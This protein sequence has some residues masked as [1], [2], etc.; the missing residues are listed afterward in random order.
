[1]HS[2]RCFNH[3][4]QGR[5][6]CDGATN[7]WMQRSKRQETIKWAPH[8]AQQVLQILWGGSTTVKDIIEKMWW[9][10]VPSKLMKN[11]WR[12]QDCNSERCRH[13][14]EQDNTDV[15]G[16]PSS[17]YT[18]ASSRWSLAICENHKPWHKSGEESVKC[19]AV[20]VSDGLLVLELNSGPWGPEVNL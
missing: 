18:N 8:L 4:P 7:T 19:A 5:R 20:R 10:N 11:T 12:D 6:G 9:Q 16:K 1:M 2:L 13:E 17:L 15:E 3:G 14:E